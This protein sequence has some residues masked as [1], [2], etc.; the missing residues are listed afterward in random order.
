[1]NFVCLYRMYDSRPFRE[2]SNDNISYLA[3]NNNCEL[4]N[5]LLMIEYYVTSKLGLNLR[6]IIKA[7]FLV[8]NLFLVIMQCYIFRFNNIYNCRVVGNAI[9][10]LILSI[11]TI[12]YYFCN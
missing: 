12:K 10:C 5:N 6:K 2:D 1:M 7:I 3:I 4:V 8:Y 11:I 9:P